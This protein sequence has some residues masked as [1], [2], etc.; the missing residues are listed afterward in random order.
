MTRVSGIV[1]QR[2]ALVAV[3]SAPIW[4]WGFQAIAEFPPCN[5]LIHDSNSYKWC[6]DAIQEESYCHSHT[7]EEC[8]G[9]GADNPDRQGWD[10]ELPPQQYTECR[11]LKNPTPETHCEVDWSP[12]VKK[13]SCI[14]DWIGGRGCIINHEVGV[15]LAPYAHSPPCIPAG[16]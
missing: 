15:V 8:Q 7:L 14:W 12:C 11:E 6:I 1:M 3:A 2:L 4:I 5:L 9:Y 16:Y 10:E 13:F